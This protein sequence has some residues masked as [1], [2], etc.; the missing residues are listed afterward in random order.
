MPA[1]R[2]ILNSS[3]ENNIIPMHEVIRI[4]FQ[5]DKKVLGCLISWPVLFE[6]KLVNRNLKLL[7][8]YGVRYSN[9]V[10]LIRMRSFILHA[11]VYKI[12]V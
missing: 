6:K 3:L 2:A 9:I 1:V 8:D 7:H 4:F 5:L 11:N 12:L 10:T